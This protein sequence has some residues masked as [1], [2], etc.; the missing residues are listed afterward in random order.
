MVEITLWSLLHVLVFVYWLGGDLGAFY[1]SQ[2]LSK[3]DVPVSQRLLAARIVGAVDMAPRSALIL[4]LPTGLSL[5]LAKGWLFLPEG[6]AIALQSGVWLISLFWLA[7]AW[8][9]HLAHGKTAPALQAFDM[10][11]RFVL[12]GMAFSTVVLHAFGHAPWP[13]FLTLKLA[14]LGTATAL[15]LL[16]RRVL[17]PLGPALAGLNGE[18]ARQAERSL[19]SCLSKARPKVVGIWLCLLLA[20][21]LGLAGQSI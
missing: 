10:G 13:L 8:Q 7:I 3:P 21:S 4:A 5:A 18:Q 16:I 9:R 15:G 14:C 6:N 19:A 2:F 20:A 11:M 1:T 12:I 17:T